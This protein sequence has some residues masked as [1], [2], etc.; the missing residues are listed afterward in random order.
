MRERVRERKASMDSGVSL[1]PGV[2]KLEEG[3]QEPTEMGE[4]VRVSCFGKSVPR[5]PTE[6]GGKSLHHLDARGS[7]GA[8]IAPTKWGIPKK[9]NKRKGTRNSQPAEKSS[10]C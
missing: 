6:K 7:S 4:K 2:H 8:G 5:I 3:G 9:K 10:F 1:S